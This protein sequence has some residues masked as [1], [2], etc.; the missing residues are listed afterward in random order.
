MAQRDFDEALAPERHLARQELV[1]NDAQ[2]VDI[3]PLVDACSLRLL[4]RDVLA[5]PQHR[6]RLRQPALD[7]E[8]AGDPEVGHLRESVARQQDV[9]RLDVTVHETVLVRERE[10]AADLER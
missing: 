3:R 1:E 10:G 6:P 2:R 9:L 4:R 8:R 7:V 5:R